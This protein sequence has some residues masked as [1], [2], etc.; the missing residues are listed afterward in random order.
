MS[1][2]PSWEFPA[3]NGVPVNP[4][5]VELEVGL[6]PSEVLDGNAHED[7]RWAMGDER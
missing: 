2:V 3:A 1:W 5:E 4:V 6:P 7:G